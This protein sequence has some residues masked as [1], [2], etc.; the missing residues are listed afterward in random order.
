M[1][2][3]RHHRTTDRPGDRSAPMISIHEGRSCVGFVLERGRRGYE[4][5]DAAEH[6][7]GCSRRRMERSTRF[8]RH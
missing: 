1:S 3:A 6:S 8:K 4:A 5:F 7:L 2:P